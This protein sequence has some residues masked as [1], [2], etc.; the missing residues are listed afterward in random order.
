R[1]DQPKKP[2]RRPPAILRSSPRRV[3]A[4]V[5]DRAR[6]NSFLHHATEGKKL[7]SDHSLLPH[8]DAVPQFEK[9]SHDRGKKCRH[10]DE[11]RVNFSVLRPALRPAHVPTKTG[12]NSDTFGN[13]EREK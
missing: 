4:S 1:S 6:E 10:D 8:Q 9:Q 3:A 12:F 5:A 11:R 13:D 7:P 2:T